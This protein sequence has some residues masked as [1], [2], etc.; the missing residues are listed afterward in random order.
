L[1]FTV[2]G[3]IPSPS[4]DFILN[5]YSK[6]NS[7]IPNFTILLINTIIFALIILIYIWWRFGITHAISFIIITGFFSAVMDFISSFVVHNYEYPGQ[8]HIPAIPDTQS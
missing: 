2:I 3:F 4:I 5:F 6:E 8:L 7:M 1:G